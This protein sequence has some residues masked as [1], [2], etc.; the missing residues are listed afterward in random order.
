MPL[1][2]PDV[3]PLDAEAAARAAEI[4]QLLPVGALGV[5]GVVIDLLAAARGSIAGPLAPRRPQLVVFAADHD[6]AEL[7]VSAALVSE[8][9]RRATDLATG[10]GLAA[11]LAVAAGVGVTV[12]DVGMS[13]GQRPGPGPWIGRRTERPDRHRGR[14]GRR[15]SSR[16]RS[17]PAGG[18]PTPRSTPAPTC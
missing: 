17:R 12:V 2:L 18:S 5:W 1:D 6:I 11:A 8:T 13:R 4:R 3:P 14:D 10:N 9:A 16:R 7:G 15:R